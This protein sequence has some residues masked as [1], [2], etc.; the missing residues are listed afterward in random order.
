MLKVIALA[1]IVAAANAGSVTLTAA[2][3]ESE[4]KTSGKNAFIKFQ[5]PW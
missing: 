1:C 3:F 4:V 2:N 5:A